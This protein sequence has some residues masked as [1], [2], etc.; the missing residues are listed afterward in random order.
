MDVSTYYPI[1]DATTQSNTVKAKNS[2]DKNAFL[3]IL[4]AQLSN[5][6]PMNSQDTSQSIA[7]MAQFSALEQAQNTNTSMEKLLV[8]TRIT[9]GSLMIGKNV[10][11]GLGDDKYV[12]A[13]VKSIIIEQGKVYLKTEK[14]IFDIDSVIGVGDFKNE[15]GN[16]E[17]INPTLK[18]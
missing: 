3:K 16:G 1:D 10:A 18:D 11:I 5:Q 9:E 12:E 2:L 6:D 17:Q 4:M 14:G 13:L 15:N 7:Q 8:S